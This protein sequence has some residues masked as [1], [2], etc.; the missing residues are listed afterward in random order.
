MIN[1]YSETS[2]HFDEKAD[3]VRKWISD[4]AQS[5]S[6]QLGEL[7]YIFCDDAYLLRINQE[8]LAH[9]DYTDIITFDYTLNKVLGGDIFISIE[10]VRDNSG[11]FKV[12][13][14]YELGRVMAHGILHLIGF[15]DKDEN[16][17]KEMRK[18]ED[19]ALSLPS[20]PFR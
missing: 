20:F 19:Q 11:Q 4:L 8:Y 9:D 12:S 15:K 16:H 6:F 7:S 18:Q 14:E 2:F 5:H 10:R 3:A 1:F 17:E 13:F